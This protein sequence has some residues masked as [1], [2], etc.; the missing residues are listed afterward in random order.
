MLTLS[1]GDRE[2]WLNGVQLNETMAS[3][4]EN[5]LISLDDYVHAHAQ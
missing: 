2:W 5:G 4:V 1:N 3:F